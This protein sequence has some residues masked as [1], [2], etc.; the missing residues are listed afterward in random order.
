M[1]HAC[2]FDSIGDLE[3]KL[4]VGLSVLATDHDNESDPAALQTL[5]KLGL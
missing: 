5:E 2:R 3:E 1:T 4:L